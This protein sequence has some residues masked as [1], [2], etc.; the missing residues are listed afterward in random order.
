MVKQMSRDRTM[1][2][3]QSDGITANKYLLLSG[4][5]QTILPRKR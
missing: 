3:R 1:M 2:K 5:G 4:L